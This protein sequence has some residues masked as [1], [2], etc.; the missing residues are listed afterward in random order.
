MF[1]NTRLNS[2]VQKKYF[3]LL[4]NGAVLDILYL[5]KGSKVFGK[6]PLLMPCIILLSLIKENASLTD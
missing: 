1:R 5:K 6:I 4:P 3:N 2:N